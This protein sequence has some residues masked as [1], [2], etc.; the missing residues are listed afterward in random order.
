MVPL[1]FAMWVGEHDGVLVVRL[2]GRLET[3]WSD[4]V[5]RVLVLRSPTAI[6]LDVSNLTAIDLAGLDALVATRQEVVSGGGRFVLRGAGGAVRAS[7]AVAGLDALVDDERVERP[8]HV[9]RVE[10]TAA[11]PQAARVEP[12][13]PVTRLSMKGGQD[14]RRSPTSTP[15]VA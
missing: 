15:K 3:P 2:A 7:F 8:D 4:E 1:P 11:A 6:C 5:R 12:V 9:E 14:A 10:L 13:G